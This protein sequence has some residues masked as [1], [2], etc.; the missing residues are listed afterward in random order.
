MVFSIRQSIVTSLR[1]GSTSR[2]VLAE[3]GRVALSDTDF[4]TLLTEATRLTA[5]GMDVRYCKALEY[6]P[7]QNRLLVRQGVGWHPGVVGHAT[8]EADLSSPAGYALHTG[9]PVISNNLPAEDRFKIPKLLS[10]H[11]VQRAIN[12][13]L[14]GDG[15]PFGVLE[16]DSEKPG[17]FTRHDIDFLQ[18]VANLISVALRRRQAEDALRQSNE[19]LEQRIEAEVAERRQAEDALRQ[20]QK[21]E[22]IGQL[23]GGVAHDFN[24]LLLVIMGNLDLLGRAVASDERLSRFVATAY[25]G[26]TRG[27]Q[28]TSQLLSFARRQMLHPERRPINELI[29]EFDVLATRM[30]GESVE[31]VFALDPGAGACEIDPAQFGSA[32]LNL[33]VN[34]RDAMPDGGT[35]TIRS[36]NRTVDA[37]SASRHADTQPGTYVVV[38]VSN[39]GTGMSAAVM[40]RVTE[41]FFTTKEAGRGTGLG[42]SQVY[43][44]VRQSGGFMTIESTLG[45]GTTIKLHL[46]Q[47]DARLTEVAT[48]TDARTGSGIILIVEDD[49]D[50]RDLV[51]VQLQELGYSSII[52]A[53]GPEALE[54][55]VA[56]ETPTID[57]LLTDVVMPGGMNGVAL[58][59]EARQR[60]PGLKALLTSGY[61]AEHIQGTADAES[62]DLPFLSKPYQQDDLA[63]AIHDALNQG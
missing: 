28:L 27:A 21:M 24:N 29:H 1:S 19:T 38:E 30:L 36:S 63:R 50:V 49:S 26:A 16:I 62:A 55:L 56:P 32:L 46:P 44:F 42:L 22:A 4:D 7:G 12:V 52:A 60:R 8:I 17:V 40:E 59:R 37:R 31:V 34:A 54:I 10:D 18:S 53:S 13:I 5:L 23:T 15:N 58:V 25:K 39:S 20:A 45:E 47:V 3:L 57:L 2:P 51:A 33:V 6:L 35:L 61:I 9:K 11:N 14:L 48:A 43:G 41:P